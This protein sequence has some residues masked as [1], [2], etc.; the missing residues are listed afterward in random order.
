MSDN[1][2][3][4]D[5]PVGAHSMDSADTCNFYIAPLPPLPPQSPDDVV[6]HKTID[7]GQ[8]D[9][10][11][12]P[13]LRHEPLTRA[14]GQVLWERAMQREAARAERMPDEKAA[15][16]ALFEAWQRLKELG[17]HEPQY[18]PK[19]GTS[20]KVIELGSTGIFDCHYHGE[21]PDGLY[22]VSD[23]HDVYPTS[24]GVAMYKLLP[25]DEE[26]R[27]QRMAEARAKYAARRKAEASALPQ[28][29]GEL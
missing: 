27:K 17:W 18:C 22:M 25:A 13:I 12:L 14:E 9:E 29:G 28:A 24:T 6:G 2:L 10:N 5:R 7:T 4:C 16:D 20:F 21:W 19:D 11:G 1:C 23:E 8:R 26:K 15:I 3:N